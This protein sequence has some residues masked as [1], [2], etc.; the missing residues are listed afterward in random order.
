MQPVLCGEVVRLEVCI[1]PAG[2]VFE[3][4]EEL[5]LKLASH[6]MVLAESEH[7]QGSFRSANE[8]R[9]F[10]HFRSGKD[11]YLELYVL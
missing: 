5:V 10:V 4:G 7:T 11:N 3:A 6:D 8:G 2:M 1:W 9:H